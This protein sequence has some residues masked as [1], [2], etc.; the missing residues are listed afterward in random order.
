M[1]LSAFV[2]P[3]AGQFAQGRPWH[4]GFFLLTFL[5]A[6]FRGLAELF[7]PMRRMW[8]M[9]DLNDPLP[10]VHFPSVFVWLGAAIVIYLVSL[11]DAWACEAGRRRNTD[12]D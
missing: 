4:G 5:G 2:A 1:F 10:E 6:F 8:M 12:P 3:G 9:D 11:V 7:L